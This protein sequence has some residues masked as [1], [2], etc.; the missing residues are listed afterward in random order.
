MPHA[1]TF[2]V[3]APSTRMIA[4]VV[5]LDAAD[6]EWTASGATSLASPIRPSG[7][8]EVS[9]SSVT[10][11]RLSYTGDIP[12]LLTNTSS[13]P[14]LSAIA[15]PMPRDPPVTSATLPVRSWSAASL[16]L[17]CARVVRENDPLYS[18]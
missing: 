11:S 10:L 16:S 15:R 6:A 2:R 18:E 5:K 17:P 3:M 1:Y 4:P 9:R 12:A 8:N 13:R 14:K 7:T